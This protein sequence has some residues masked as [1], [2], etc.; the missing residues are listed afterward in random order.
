MK[1]RRHHW[2][3]LALLALA[4][5]PYITAGNA[6]ANVA[7][8]RWGEKILAAT[9]GNVADAKH[10]VLFRLHDLTVLGSAA[11]ALVLLH[12][13]ITGGLLR[14]SGF[15]RQPWVASALSLFV[16]GNIWLLL[17]MQTGLFWIGFWQGRDH[18]A[19]L[20]RFEMKRQLLAEHPAPG[21]AV[22]L[23][24]SQARAQI[25]EAQLN[26]LLAPDL[27]TGELHFPGSQAFDI[28]LA[29]RQLA[30]SS[31]QIVIC[32]ISELSI[33]QPVSGEAAPYLLGWK[34]LRT[35]SDLGGLPL[36][37]ARKLGYGLFGNILPVFYLRDALSRRLL[38]PGVADIGQRQH[39]QAMHVETA[40][41]L[42][43][44]AAGFHRADASA[45]FQ[46][47]ALAA[48]VADCERQGQT[49]V[50]IAGQFNPRLSAR[51]D[52]AIRQDM[53][54]FLE[55]LR[56]QS[57]RVVLITDS[58]A[59]AEADYEDLTHVNKQ[60]QQAYTAFLAAHLRTVQKGL[61]AKPK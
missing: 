37:P 22:I 32:Y 52:P 57:A 58:P 15:R 56:Q 30:P 29:H 20:V 27:Y 44:R 11:F 2:V 31:A 59:Q 35:T 19:P 5:L 51:V 61:V 50:L 46:K 41:E 45:E 13:L 42:D 18:T 7:A 16:L 26:A 4:W 47:R 6:L 53:L 10:F 40:A 43:A 23:G 12:G 1:L 38:G 8:G 48:F 21:K 36:L 39:D 24:S 9:D 28:W 49:L 54:A 14:W 33:Y 34:D 3:C 17:A 25:E 60:T 55:G